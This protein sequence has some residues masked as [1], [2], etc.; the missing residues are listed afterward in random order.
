MAKQ[1]QIIAAL[2]LF[3]LL[4]A[5]SV[6]GCVKNTGS[7]MPEALLPTGALEDSLVGVWEVTNLDVSAIR[8]QI[9]AAPLQ[10]DRDGLTAKIT[11]VQNTLMGMKMT[12]R[13]D[14]TYETSLNQNYLNGT[15]TVNNRDFTPHSL[16]RET[17][18]RTLSIMSLGA[19]TFVAKCNYGGS[20]VV[21]TYTRR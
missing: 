11:K 16:T 14:H 18:D 17:I 20:I 3:F 6:F 13:Q 19:T 10:A 1:N 12:V 8:A 5:G 4:G 2:F 9:A 7:N 15:W 21:I